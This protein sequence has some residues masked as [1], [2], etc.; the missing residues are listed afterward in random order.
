MAGPRRSGMAGYRALYVDYTKGSG[1]T[2]FEYNMTM[3][4]PIIGLTARATIYFELFSS[5][6]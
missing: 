1:L 2:H 4:G 6:S 3:H 5:R